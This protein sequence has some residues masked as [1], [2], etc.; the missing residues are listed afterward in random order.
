MARRAHRCWNRP[1]NVTMPLYG[2]RHR[3]QKKVEAERRV[4]GVLARPGD[5]ETIN[6]TWYRCFL[7]N[8][9]ERSAL[10]VAS[11]PRGH[12]PVRPNYGA[13]ITPGTLLLPDHACYPTWVFIPGFSGMRNTAR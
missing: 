12:D 1:Y 3:G 10:L 5:R 6:V 2:R 9:V 11:A 7:C 13:K 8:D 4:G